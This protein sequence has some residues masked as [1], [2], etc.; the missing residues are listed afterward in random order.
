MADFAILNLAHV[1]TLIWPPCRKQKVATVWAVVARNGGRLN[2]RQRSGRGC[3]RRCR[4]WHW[5]SPRYGSTCGNG[6]GS[7]GWPVERRS[8]RRA[9]AGGSMQKAGGAGGLHAFGTVP[10]PRMLA[11][12]YRPVLGQT[13]GGRQTSGRSHETAEPRN[14]TIRMK[15]I[16][17]LWH[18][19]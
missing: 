3:G 12:E 1:D 18:L 5:G 2:R 10:G 8:S 15:H 19:Y 4:G 9:T 13:Q 16:L 7:W 17:R 6:N 14:R 11:G